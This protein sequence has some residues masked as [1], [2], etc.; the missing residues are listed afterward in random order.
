[1]SQL[2]ENYYCAFYFSSGWHNALLRFFKGIT[3]FISKMWDVLLG[4][5]LVFLCHPCEGYLTNEKVISKA[6][7]L[8]FKLT[9]RGTGRGCA[10]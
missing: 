6:V 9:L 2:P 7:V 5:V 10:T 4:D 8:K 1:M 3:I